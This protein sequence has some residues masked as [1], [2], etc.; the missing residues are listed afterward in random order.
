MNVIKPKSSNKNRELMIE[1]RRFPPPWSA[2]H[3]V[4]TKTD[5]PR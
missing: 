3:K 1:A 5:N 4:G 2:P